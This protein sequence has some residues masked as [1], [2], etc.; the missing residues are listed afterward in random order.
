MKIVDFERYPYEISNLDVHIDKSEYTITW[1]WPKDIEFVFIVKLDE[2]ENFSI[3]N[4]D[5]Y[6]IKMYTKEEYKEFNGYVKK[7]KSIKQYVYIVFPGIQS[8]EDLLLVNQNNNNNKLLV[9]TGSPEIVYRIKEIRDLKSLFSSER[10][11]QIIVSSEV[12]LKKDVLCYV[13]KKGEY[14]VSLED[15]ICFDFI[16]DFDIGTNVLP[17]IVINKNEYIRVF[18]KDFNRYGNVY[19]LKQE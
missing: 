8:G 19:K 10:K 2:Y 17:E 7:I 11:V 9:S 5:K 6:K 12:P 15:G 4:I 16:D 18:I 1:K 13:K 14:P 3:N